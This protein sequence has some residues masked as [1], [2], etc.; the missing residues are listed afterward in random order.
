MAEPLTALSITRNAW[1]VAGLLLLAVGIGD[2]AVA[3]TK[4]SQYQE[5]LASTPAKAPKNPAVLFPKASEAE[6][7]RSVARAKLGSHALSGRAA[8]HVRRTRPDRRRRR[9]GAFPQRTR[10][11]DRKFAL[12]SGRPLS[13]SR[14][15]LH[16][17]RTAGPRWRVRGGW[18][19]PQV[20][21]GRI[22]QDVRARSLEGRASS[23][24]SSLFSSGRSTSTGFSSSSKTRPGDRYAA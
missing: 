10:R 12:T 13:T 18:L 23:T 4:L 6:E 5:T 14:T 22:P 20:G 24:R 11:S 7:Q 17:G 19:Q 9:P 15:N 16:I 21:R 1:I 2:V 3:R 8:A